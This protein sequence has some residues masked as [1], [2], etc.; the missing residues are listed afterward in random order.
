MKTKLLYRF[1]QTLAGSELGS[2][3][4]RDLDLLAGAGVDAFAGF[5]LGN[6]KD[7]EARDIDA[8]ALDHGL[9]NGIKNSVHRFRGFRFG[10]AGFGRHR[11]DK[12]ILGHCFIK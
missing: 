9:G 6:S 2:G 3:F 12:L 4:S 11:A 10:L 1:F 8:V 7:A 5:S